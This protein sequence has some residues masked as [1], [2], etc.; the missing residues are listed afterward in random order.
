MTGLLGRADEL[1][2]VLDR[3]DDHRL[4]TVVGPG[5]IGKTVLA[6]AAAEEAVDRFAAGSR[7]V[8]LTLVDEP[9][10]VAGA[11]AAQL[12]FASFPDLL[13]SPSEQPV[14]LVVDNCE[15]VLDAAADA[16]DALLDACEA[17][18]VIATSRSP[19]DLPG[20]SIVALGPLDPAVASVELF[21]TRS[22]DAGTRLTDDEDE[23]VA[24]LCRALDGIPLAIEIAAA[25]TRVLRPKEILERLGDL[26][27]LSRPRRRGDDRHRALRSTIEWS[28]HQVREADRRAFDRLG[29]PA[30]RISL[31]TAHALVADDPAERDGSTMEIL[32][33]LVGH[34]LLVADPAGGHRM[35][36]PL[37][38]FA[39]EQLA[40]RGELDRTWDRYVTH[41]LRRVDGLNRR[42][43]S[44]WDA[45]ALAELLDLS[46]H[47]LTAVRWTVA[48][49]DGPERSI[50]L[51]ASLWGVLHHAHTDDISDAG[52]QLLRRWPTPTGRPAALA[53][54]T[55][56]TSRHLEGDAEEAI[57][58]ADL[59][60]RAVRP[61]RVPA[62]VHRATAM[63]KAATGDLEGARSAFADALAAAEA[64]GV[65]V[66]ERES[67]VCLTVIRAEL[68][69]DVSGELSALA[70][71]ARHAGDGVNAAWARLAEG[72]TLLRHEPARAITVLESALAD[73]RSL[74]YRPGVVGALQGL[75]QAAAAVGDLSA[76]ADHLV[77]LIDEVTLHGAV[78]ERH[79]LLRTAAAVLERSGDPRWEELA[80]TA[81]ALPRISL[82]TR[83]GA[84]VLPLPSARGRPR[85][86]GAALADARR[87][88]VALRD[89]STPAVDSTVASDAA[90]ADTPEV[91]TFRRHGDAWEVEFAGRRLVVRDSKG[92]RDL[93]RLLAAPDREIHCLELAGAAAEEAGTGEVIDAGARRA[94]EERIREL[95][96]EID[97]ADSHH[98]RA[99]ADRA[100]GEFD[101]IVDHLAASLGLGG[102]VRRSGGTAERARSAVTHRVRA[103]LRRLDGEHPEL[104]RHLTASISTGAYLAYRPERPVTW[105]T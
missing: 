57:A 50:A 48:H 69:E 102:R 8:D 29:V 19:L 7:F 101:A 12:G 42:G 21:R 40:N 73:A 36:H 84:E 100:Q 61:D 85:P 32:E 39:L 35:L 4:V 83:V 64:Q 15:H 82:F 71:E 14:L 30:G 47:L 98:D 77:A 23:A 88:L 41:L 5:G 87:L 34:S 92:M 81:D 58:L 46:D 66:L 62:V 97:E 17:P 104:G 37:R 22:R 105:E 43:R 51:I 99:R 94:Y 45:G 33:A 68:G 55:L 28:Y 91:G 63:A 78:S 80:A 103:T 89:G 67:R 6:R 9:G 76:A 56:A 3:L 53:L 31:D 44:A 11:V 49:D 59:A 27:T 70:D 72:Q 90:S 79:G 16:V 20:E 18:T 26:D 25:R 52:G 2:A 75:A 10:A 86:T 93:A 96:A 54:A 38:T 95:Q 24:A 13:D 74:A 65:P 1:T 60:A